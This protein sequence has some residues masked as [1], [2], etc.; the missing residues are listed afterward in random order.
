LIDKVR[1]LYSK[2]KCTQRAIADYLGISAP[3]L[4]DVFAGRHGLTGGQVFRAQ[5]L[6]KT[7]K[8][9]QRT[10][11]PPPVD[12]DD[13]D[14]GEM[15]EEP[16]TLAEA[17]VVI[18]ARQKELSFLQ[19][20]LASHTGSKPAV[21]VPQSLPTARPSS[22]TG[23]FATPKRNASG[24]PC[25]LP[26]DPQNQETWDGYNKAVIPFPDGCDTPA[27]IG[28]HLATV[29]SERLPWYLKG[30]PKTPTEKLQRKMVAS[31][32]EAR[33]GNS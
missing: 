1:S 28:S 32:L 7:I 33:E 29:S 15:S 8:T 9:Q 3:Q 25:G 30:A 14:R 21:A 10:M 6:L 23:T 19:Q 20:K 26:F 22:P 17:K 13:D 2:G 5:Q 18:Q 4:S 12:D 16:K 27:A 31:E 24:Q 11:R